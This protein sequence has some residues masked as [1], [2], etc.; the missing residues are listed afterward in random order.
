VL[1]FKRRL[2][3]GWHGGER[4]QARLDEAG[5]VSDGSGRVPGHDLSLARVEGK[6]VTLVLLETEN[7]SIIKPFQLGQRYTTTQGVRRLRLCADDETGAW[8]QAFMH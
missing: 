8:H 7:T 4:R 5:R 3:P 2:R 6:F 1:D